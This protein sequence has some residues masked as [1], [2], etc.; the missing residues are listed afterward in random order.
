LKRSNLGEERN[1]DLQLK[2]QMLY[3][4][5]NCLKE[6]VKALYQS[7]FQD[8]RFLNALEVQGDGISTLKFMKKKM[9]TE[10]RVNLNFDPLE[11]AIPDKGRHGHFEST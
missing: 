3:I 6:R 1:V 8:I 11:G 5:E 2:F 4:E 7:L 9:K 10:L